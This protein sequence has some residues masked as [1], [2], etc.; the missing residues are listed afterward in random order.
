MK[1]EDLDASESSSSSLAASLSESLPLL[2]TVSPRPS[3]SSEP[4]VVGEPTPSSPP[5]RALTPPGVSV[6]PSPPKRARPPLRRGGSFLNLVP[7]PSTS[8]SLGRASP[9]VP[10]S[11]ELLPTVRTHGRVARW[12]F[13]LCLPLST[14]RAYLG[15]RP[16]QCKTVF[17]R[18]I[19]CGPTPLPGR[20]QR[21]VD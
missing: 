12:F 2:P 16:S 10:R 15:A 11:P 1:A 19:L 3:R 6:S 5:R 18:M 20:P 17:H 8:P 13:S 4:Q 7:I 14:R 21:P 9:V